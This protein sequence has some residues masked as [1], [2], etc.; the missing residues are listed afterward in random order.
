MGKCLKTF[1]FLVFLFVFAFLFILSIN[2]RKKNLPMVRYCCQNESKFCDNFNEVTAKE[3][4]P[5]WDNTRF[6]VIKGM[7][8]CELGF[9]DKTDFYMNKVRILCSLSE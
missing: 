4:N 9:Y 6:K 3:I 5:K 8:L 2:L 7:I 1:L